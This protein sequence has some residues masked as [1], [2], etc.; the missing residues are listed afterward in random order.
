[1]ERVRIGILGL[2]MWGREVHL[3]NLL[4]IPEAQITALA[5]RTPELLASAAEL[6]PEPKPQLFNDYDQLLASDACDAV[7]I[8]TASHTHEEMVLKA[9]ETEKHILC[10]KPLSFTRE[11]AQRILEAYQQGP[12]GR[13]FQIGLE[14]RYSD[15]VR[16]LVELLKKGLVGVPRM[17]GCVILRDWGKPSGWRAFRKTS[18]NIFHEL[19]CHYLDLLNLFA[20]SL[21]SSIVGTGGKALGTEIADYLWVSL[22]Y[23]NQTIG[24]L[25]ICVFAPAR[26]LIPLEIIGVEG[27]LYGE[28][29]EGQVQFWPRG[30][31]EP[32]DYSPP[33]PPDYSFFGFPGSL[34][35]L[36]AF[37]HSIQTGT[38]PDAN[39]QVAYEAVV[40]SLAA[41]QAIE[42]VSKTTL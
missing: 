13:I 27:R 11:G 18:G 28:V 33:R 14:L 38:P 4:Q 12:Q 40:T 20:G 26:N 7:I 1:M 22:S 36:K 17:L 9:L 35:S 34:E 3:P 8:A 2:G 42:K 31:E 5:S 16:R 32:V 39:L 25:G 30:K 10:E 41:D 23:P 15:V 6:V 24:N 19:G 29:I 37:I 21:P